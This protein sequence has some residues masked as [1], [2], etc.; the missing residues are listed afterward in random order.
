MKEVRQILKSISEGRIAPV[1]FLHGE[2]P[3]YIDLITDLIEKNAL[4][5]AAKG[6][7]QVVMYGKDVKVIDVLNQARRFPMMS[8]RQVVIVKEAQNIQD[9]G[10]SEGE[11]HLIKY[12][13]NPLPSTIL[14][15]AHKHKTL[16]K[17]KSLF[18][19]LDK[20]AVVL[21]SNKLYDNQV[22]DW[23]REYFSERQI[24][25]T[26]KAVFMLAENIGNNLERLSNEIEKMLINFKEKVKVD[27]HIIHKYIGISK[28]YN[29][30][31]L[32]KAIA[33]REISRANKIVN[34]FEAN[35]KANPVIPVIATLFSFFSRLLIVYTAKDKTE[36]GV[37]AALKVNR[38]FVKDYLIAAGKYPYFQTLNII[39]ALRHADLQSKG[40][41]VANLEDGA[42]LKELTFK[43]LHWD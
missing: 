22:P 13:Q 1:Y 29:M 38:F 31:E 11:Q 12:I 41:N 32:Q 35:P 8:D 10:K 19:A 42:I 23:I 4:D 21:T 3:Y 33:Y 34:Y 7:N 9:L 40:V 27:E 26:D 2:E 6:F 16:D 24:G 28:D 30:F 18:L 5:E 25:I 17:R 37:A 15:L 39:H 20:H 43:I 36:A 14:V